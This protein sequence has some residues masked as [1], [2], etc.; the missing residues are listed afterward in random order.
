ML[1]FIL[2]GIIFAAFGIFLFLRPDLF[3]KLTEQWKSY[4]ADEPSDLYVKSTKFGGI[5]F[6]LLGV[7]MIVLPLVLE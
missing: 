3:W 5:L 7:A 6:V 1:L 4:Y 2:G